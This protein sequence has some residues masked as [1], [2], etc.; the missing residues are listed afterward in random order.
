MGVMSQK[1]VLN[2]ECKSGDKVAFDVL[3]F[4]D[5]SGFVWFRALKFFK[6]TWKN[7]LRRHRKYILI[8]LGPI[9]K[10]KMCLKESMLRLKTKDTVNNNEVVFMV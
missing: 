10:R 7:R 9:L 5:I 4:I 3:H 8:P 2:Y 6:G 1:S